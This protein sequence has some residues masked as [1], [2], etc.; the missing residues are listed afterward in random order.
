[1]RKYPARH[2]NYYDYDENE[3]LECP[4]CHWKGSSKNN[5]EIYDILLDVTCPTCD[6]MLLIVNYPTTEEVKQALNSGNVKAAGDYMSVLATEAYNKYFEEKKL[7]S[8]EQLPEIQGDELD[9][10]WDFENLPIDGMFNSETVIRYKEVVLWREPAFW[11]GWFRF[12]QI[13]EILSQKYGNYF[14]SLKP[15]PESE[16]YLYG[17][18]MLAPSKITSERSND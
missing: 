4:V 11:E 3:I 10:I 13:K 14:H 9:F 1:M 8:V 7:K 5:T 16:L 15:T 6:K 12:N 2:L 17:D 18:D